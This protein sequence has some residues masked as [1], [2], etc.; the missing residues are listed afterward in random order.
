MRNPRIGIVD[1]GVNNLTSVLNAFRHLGFS[2]EAVD[3]PVRLGGFTHLVLPGVGSFPSGMAHLRA[4]GFVDALPRAVAAGMPL[5]GLCL[6][7]QMLAEGSDEFETT[8]GLGLVPGR[9]GRLSCAGLSLPHVG[10]NEVL[11]RRASRLMDG[12]DAGTPFY[13]VH[14][15][16]YAAP[17]EE[18]VVGVCNYGGLV[19]AVIEHGNIY[20]T[21]FHPEKSQKAGLA[22][23]R[24]F[25]TLC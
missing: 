1:Y 19:P 5:L 22:L 13:F 4:S 23:L 2:V 8:Q 18:T 11:L 17:T 7:M 9:V 21:Q 10:W 14:S 3:S 6:G 16:A 24:N 12:L 25:A 15:Y 20:G